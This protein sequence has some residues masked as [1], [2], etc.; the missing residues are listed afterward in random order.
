MEIINYCYH[1]N[2]TTKKL[3]NFKLN[4]I[5]FRFKIEEYII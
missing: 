1:W 2:S 4:F 5:K 3:D